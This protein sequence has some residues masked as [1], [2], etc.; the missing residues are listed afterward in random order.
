MQDTAKENREIKKALRKEYKEYKISVVQGQGTA[1][2]WKEIS[3]DTDI[4]AEFNEWDEGTYT[5]ELKDKLI[6]I[7]KRVKEIVKESA[8]LSTYLTD[9]AYGEDRDCLLVTVNTIR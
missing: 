9:D 2:E 3:I 1:C 7:E 5:T 8:Q 6:T 4:K